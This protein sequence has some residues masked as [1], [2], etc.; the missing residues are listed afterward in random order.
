[1]RWWAEKVGKQNVVELAN[2]AYGIP[3]RVY[4]IN[5]SKAKPLDGGQLGAIRDV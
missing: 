2:A 4:V 3:D 5:A 1:V